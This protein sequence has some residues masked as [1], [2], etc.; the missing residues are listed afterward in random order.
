MAE[1]LTTWTATV[2]E[3]DRL[4]GHARGRAAAAPTLIDQG[5]LL[6]L[7]TGNVEAAAHIKL[8]RARLNRFFSFGGYGSDST[9]RTELTR[10]ALERATV[11]S[12]G[13]LDPDA[14][15]V[16]GDTP[17]DIDAGHG[18]GVRVVAVATGS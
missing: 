2:A 8:S 5:V 14:C 7:T 18:A 11:V 17:L 12:G 13:L 4:P 1:R 9:D 15:V 10:R 3:S 6:G 16:V